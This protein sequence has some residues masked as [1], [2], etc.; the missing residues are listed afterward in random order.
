MKIVYH[1]DFLQIYTRDPAAAPG[2]LEPILEEL[3]KENFEIIE[4]YPAG[5]DDLL[6]VHTERHIQSVAH[7]GLY[8]IAALAAGGAMLAAETGLKE[9]CFAVIR[10]PGHHASS[11]SAWGFCFFNNMAVAIEYLRAS[12]K[13][14]SAF[15][16]DFDLHYG[17]G[18]VNILGNR[19][20][21]TIFNPE[22]RSRKDYIASVERALHQVSP[23]II[24]VSAGFDN[25]VD[26]WGGL[27]TTEDYYTMGRLV[28]ER[29]KEV[30]CGCFGILEG[31]Y[32]HQVLGKNVR[33]FVRGL[34]GLPP[35]SS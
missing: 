7:R 15:I 24:G 21:I 32:N 5:W 27:L 8:N 13:I 10:P 6:R 19:E 3:L 33:A 18:T 22:A 2:R 34:G 30:G 31:G 20:N 26:D 25:H 4:A 1:P 14:S 17:D 23:D 9:P 11:D 16:L 29:S 12:G 28:F 35:L